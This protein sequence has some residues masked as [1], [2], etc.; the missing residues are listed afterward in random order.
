MLSPERVL[1]AAIIAMAI[2]GLAN[3]SAARSLHCSVCGMVKRE[4]LASVYAGSGNSQPSEAGAKLEGL[5]N[6]AIF[7]R[8][9]K[10]EHK[11]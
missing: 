2:P 6:N 10:Y 7:T 11:I 1:A 9:T 4:V 3:P 5:G 8:C